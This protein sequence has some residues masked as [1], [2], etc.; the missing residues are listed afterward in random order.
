MNGI[1]QQC[2]RNL[3]LFDTLDVRIRG[4]KACIV[5]TIAADDRLAIRVIHRMRQILSEA[6]ETSAKRLLHLLFIFCTLAFRSRRKAQHQIFLSLEVAN[7]LLMHPDQVCKVCISSVL[8]YE[9]DHHL[10]SL[11]VQP[12]KCSTDRSRTLDCDSF[13]SDRTCKRPDAVGICIVCASPAECAFYLANLDRID[14][15]STLQK[16]CYLVAF[17]CQDTGIRFSHSKRHWLTSSRNGNVVD[18]HHIGSLTGSNR[19]GILATGTAVVDRNPGQLLKSGRP[20]TSCGKRIAPTDNTRQHSRLLQIFY[21]CF[22]PIQSFFCLLRTGFQLFQRSIHLC[23]AFFQLSVVHIGTPV[24]VFTLEEGCHIFIGKTVIR[25]SIILPVPFR[26][27]YNRL[28]S[29]ILPGVPDAKPA[30]TECSCFFL[31]S[32]YFQYFLRKSKPPDI[33]LSFSVNGTLQHW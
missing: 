2:L 29:G 5:Q 19:S 8:A 14:V 6:D 3:S 9:K 30:G 16:R 22:L 20:S 24:G 17:F 27:P 10:G 25:K 26:S 13:T 28:L 32:D 12:V 31:Y 15:S 4:I 7:H 18:Q 23:K 33:H 21:S 1:R 11:I